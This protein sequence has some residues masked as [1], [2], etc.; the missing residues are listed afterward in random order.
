MNSGVIG[1]LCGIMVHEA[2]QNWPD[3]ILLVNSRRE[4]EREID[5]ELTN[6]VN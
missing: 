4:K 1:L 6:K 2:F 3:K 5:R